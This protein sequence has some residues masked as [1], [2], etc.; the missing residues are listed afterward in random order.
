MITKMATSLE[1]PGIPADD[2]GLPSPIPTPDMRD[3]ARA[4]VADIARDA[5]SHIKR[6]AD[7][8][9]DPSLAGG[10]AGVAVFL[11]YTANALDDDDVRTT[12]VDL[13]D[14]ALAGLHSL[15][16]PGLF[17][18]YS[19]VAW[20]VSHL[21]QR[22]VAE[23]QDV[24]LAEI[25]A[26]VEALLRRVPWHDDYDLISGLVGL[27]VY[28]LERMHQGAGEGIV[29]A[30]VNHLFQRAEWVGDGATWFHPPWSVPE[31]QREA[32]TEGW[33]NLG[34]AHGV[35]GVLAFLARAARYDVRRATATRLLA[36]GS[37]WTCAQV[38][39]LG[40][41][42]VRLGCHVDPRAPHAEPSFRDAWCYGSPGAAVALLAAAR[43]LG[44]ERAGAYSLALARTAARHDPAQSG[45]VD[46]SF[47]HGSSGL[48][49]LYARL[50]A[51]TGEP[52]FADAARRALA[53][54]LAFKTPCEG[55]GGFSYATWDGDQRAW[56]AS[57]NFLEGA[58]GI[59]LVLLS[60]CSS[61]PPS[62][63]RV[64]LADPSP[65]FHRAS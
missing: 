1:A 7:G 53:H 11:H 30:V 61:E 33:Y 34:V 19:G 37:R 54:T 28:G 31:G 18:G 42:E 13:L 15:R 46:A 4:A 22:G 29:A 45:V 57:S 24:D 36:A 43:V 41:D 2:P 3:A 32:F 6:L 60:I 27:G 9:L 40:P 62:W 59:G 49:H 50:H 8:T 65:S 56:E 26:I 64:V 5:P 35:P 23:L 52:L 12:C 51:S 55:V 47:C 44:D 25:D 14:Q 63:D 16:Y 38:R 17:A 39:V 58:A 10:A 21:Q 20:A 48:A